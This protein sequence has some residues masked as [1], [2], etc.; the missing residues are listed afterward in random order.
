MGKHKKGNYKKTPAELRAYKNFIDHSTY[1]PESTI[2]VQ[3]EML[4][5]SSEYGRCDGKIDSSNNIKKAP[6]RYRIGDWLKKNIF[7]VLISTVLIAIAS[8][9]IAHQVN[10]AVIN[11]QIEYIEK[12]IEQLDSNSVDRE[13]LDLKLREITTQL[14]SSYSITFNDIKWELKELEEKVNSI[15]G[16]DKDTED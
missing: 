11:K 12:R 6:L 15:D 14:D 10:I 16:A 3:N 7:P 9:V 1:N 8:A 2:P 4:Q 5:G 13:V